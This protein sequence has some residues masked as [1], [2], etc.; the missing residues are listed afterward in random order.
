M[1][2]RQAICRMRRWGCTIRSSRGLPS[3]TAR[4]DAG[5]WAVGCKGLVDVHAL[6]PLRRYIAFQDMA[7]AAA[8]HS[9]SPPPGL[10][11]SARHWA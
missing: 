1:H 11:C 6:L 8:A 3:Q 4:C 10:A 5:G 7:R 2:A 9:C